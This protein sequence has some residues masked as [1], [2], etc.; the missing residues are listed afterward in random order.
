MDIADY[1]LFKMIVGELNSKKASLNKTDMTLEDNQT[2]K[3]THTLNMTKLNDVLIS[4]KSE[5]VVF[6]F[7]KDGSAKGL[8]IDVIEDNKE[9]SY[10]MGFIK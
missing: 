1:N 3:F 4:F 9:L 8:S 10:I 7:N 6:K 5:N 2:A